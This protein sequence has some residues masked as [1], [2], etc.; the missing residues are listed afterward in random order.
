VADGTRQ[1]LGIAML[2]IACLAAPAAARAVGDAQAGRDLAVR[3]CGACHVTDRTGAG[4]DAA[5]PFPEIA[6]RTHADHGWVRAWLAKP[7]PP[8]PDLSLTRQQ[9]DDIVAYLDRLAP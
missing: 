6:H 4:T 8:M 5:P 9:I 2:M 3:S 7:H 1:G